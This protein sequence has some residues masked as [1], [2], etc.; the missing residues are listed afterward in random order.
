MYKTNSSTCSDEAKDLISEFPFPKSSQESTVTY[1]SYTSE[2]IRQ[3]INIPINARIG[4]K[5]L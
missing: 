5:K 3:P 1:N 2:K 4:L